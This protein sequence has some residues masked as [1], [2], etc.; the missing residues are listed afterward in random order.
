[1]TE[2]QPVSMLGDDLAADAKSAC[3]ACLACS[4]DE[5]RWEPCWTA[6]AEAL[7]LEQVQRAGSQNV[8]VVGPGV[9]VQDLS[10]G[11]A[12][13][14]RLTSTHTPCWAANTIW[15]SAASA[16]TPGRPS[17]ARPSAD[18]SFWPPMRL[19]V[20]PSAKPQSNSVPLCTTSK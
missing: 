10:L 7:V 13:G 19:E 9:N 2:V 6:T 20:R 1:M 11:T 3:D 5:C 18:P 14:P 8:F 15:K 16:S 12:V 4:L 17:T